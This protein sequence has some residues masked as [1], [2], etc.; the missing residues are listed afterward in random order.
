MNISNFEWID[1][2]TLLT[3]PRLLREIEILFLVLLKPIVWHIPVL[4]R[5][6]F[7]LVPLSIQSF[8]KHLLTLTM[9]LTYGLVILLRLQIQP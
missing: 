2:S 4:L 5:L 8:A 3:F 7:Q 6:E 1:P 9:A